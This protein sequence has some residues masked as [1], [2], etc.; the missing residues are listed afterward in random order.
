MIHNNNYVKKRYYL[1][2]LTVC[3]IIL[4]THK[5][6]SNKPPPLVFMSHFSHPQR[7]CDPT[8]PKHLPHTR[9][10][11]PA[12]QRPMASVLYPH[13]T[14]HRHSLRKRLA[15]FDRTR[16]PHQGHSWRGDAR[17]DVAHLLSRRVG[18]SVGLVEVSLRPQFFQRKWQLQFK[19][20]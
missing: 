4:S 5:L 18:S 16:A 9:T 7:D 14:A 10:E 12:Q 13:L 3:S 8:A 6:V 11:P 1:Y 17:P 15:C 19:K 2:P 20:I